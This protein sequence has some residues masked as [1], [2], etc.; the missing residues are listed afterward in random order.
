M[1][2]I[3]LRDQALVAALAKNLVK[4]VAPEEL[5]LFDELLTDYMHDP[6]PPSKKTSKEHALGS[7]FGFVMTAV[8]P[9][10]AA[11]ANTAVSFIETSRQATA[12]VLPEQTRTD[13]QSRLES[14]PVSEMP[15]LDKEQ[16]AQLRQATLNAAMQYGMNRAQ[17]E[18]LTNAILV[19][20][21]LGPNANVSMDRPIRILF[22]SANPS[23]LDHLAVEQEVRSIDEA[24][25][26]SDYR[27]RF[28]FEQ[29]WSVRISDLQ[30]LLLRN[31]PDI[32]HFSGHGTQKE[33]LMLDTQDGEPC[34][35]PNEALSDLFRLFQ[36]NVRCVVLNACYSA[37]QAQAI[38]KC[39][40]CVVGMSNLLD[41]SS[42]II[43]SAAFYQ[44]L[45]YGK[46][47]LVAFELGVN[48]LKLEQRAAAA[49][50]T[51]L[52]RDESAKEITFA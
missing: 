15:L 25:R 48:E 10:A 7:G 24:L 20:L 8:T 49:V 6:T 32:L 22:L 17:A 28:R 11:V 35:I 12:N 4:Q 38:V 30:R 21:M 1:S 3:P 47:V 23:Q 14:K 31:E 13:L 50:P 43:F 29:H 26:A 37:E 51:I 2:S 18:Q 46:T 34:P 19:S 44:A 5:D 16:L 36:N 41:D 42:A 40:P 27:D 45:A 9:A 52:F 33:G 39:I